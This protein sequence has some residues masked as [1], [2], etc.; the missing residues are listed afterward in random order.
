MNTYASLFHTSLQVLL[1]KLS[2][3]FKGMRY[4]LGDTYSMTKVIMEKPVPLGTLEVKKACC[5]KGK[6][7]AELP[8]KPDSNLCQN[9]HSY[10]FWDQYHLTQAASG[11]LAMY[12]YEG[13]PVLVSPMSFGEL[14]VA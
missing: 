13:A 2:S 9:R 12:L 4:A 11:M 1:Q 3:Q 8:C 10:L 5:G 14:A 7:N 6:L